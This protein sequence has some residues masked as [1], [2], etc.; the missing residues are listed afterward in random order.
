M[1]ERGTKVGG[2]SGLD[3]FP[4]IEPSRHGMFDVDDRHT[5]YWEETGNPDGIPVVFL[6][7]GPGAGCSPN[8]RR[9]FDPKAYRIF[10]FD[11]RGAGRSTPYAEITDNTTHHLIADI[12]ALREEFGVDRWL[13]FG[14]SWGATLAVAYATRHAERCL[15]MILRGVFLAR[16]SELA[17]FLGGVGAVRPEAWER[18]VCFLPESERGDVLAAY[19]LRLMDTA[20][21]IN[22][23]AARAWNAFETECSTLRSEGGGNVAGSPSLALARIEAHYFVN[24]MFLDLDLLSEVTKISHLPCVI[25]QGR[26]DMVCPMVTAREL[27]LAWPG[28]RLVIINDAGHSAM[29]PGIRRGLVAVTEVFKVNRDFSAV[30]SS[31]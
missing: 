13:V 29:E 20:S 9:F 6:H 1:R 7:G 15:G 30:S 11:Q 31:P 24:G 19:H 25:V 26:Y 17:W 4:T 27:H 12:E 5:L 18:F 22:G 2:Q 8:H 16:T 14:G 3:P 21:D 10:L 23:R 28:S